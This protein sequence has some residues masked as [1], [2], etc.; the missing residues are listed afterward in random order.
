MIIEVTCADSRAGDTLRFMR[1]EVGA[2]PRVGDWLS[3]PDGSYR[4]MTVVTV[5]AFELGTDTSG[6]V[7]ARVGVA[8][9]P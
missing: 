9:S 6:Q 4:Q 5:F 7:V 8:Y 2:V 1:Y 3:Y